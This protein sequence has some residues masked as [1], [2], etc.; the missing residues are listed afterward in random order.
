MLH[1][2]NAK[3]KERKSKMQLAAEQNFVL[4]Y[5]SG[6]SFPISSQRGAVKK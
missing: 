5:A 6:S 3:G 1:E 4:V 2:C